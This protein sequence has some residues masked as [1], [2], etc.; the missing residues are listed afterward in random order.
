MLRSQS[1]KKKDLSASN[2]RPVL[3]I[4][5]RILLGSAVPGNLHLVFV[6]F[7]KHTLGFCDRLLFGSGKRNENFC[8]DSNTF[9]LVSF[10]SLLQNMESWKT[11]LRIWTQ[12][13]IVNASLYTYNYI[14]TIA[15]YPS[16]EEDSLL[17][18][19]N[20]ADKAHNCGKAA[21]VTMMVVILLQASEYWITGYHISEYQM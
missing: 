4:P 9:P 7:E 13:T 18:M 17:E 19:V 3:L 21:L 12:M 8:S 11:F 5:I 15:S 2:I 6:L 16:G 14:E 1:T 20:I 10:M